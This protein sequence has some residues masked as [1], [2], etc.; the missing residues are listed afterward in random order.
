MIKIGPSFT[1]NP[2]S[3]GTK[4][5]GGIGFTFLNKKIGDNYTWFPPDG[6]ESIP[7]DPAIPNGVTSGLTF[8]LDFGLF[9]RN[10]D[11]YYAGISSTSLIQS[12]FTDFGITRTRHLVIAVVRRLL[13]M[14][15]NSLVRRLK[16]SRRFFARS[17]KIWFASFAMLPAIS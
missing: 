17:A 16:T 14:G 15:R 11:K 10:S 8:D 4:I 5:S 3:S 7:S 9:M 6:Q 1:F 13:E 12:A 2:N